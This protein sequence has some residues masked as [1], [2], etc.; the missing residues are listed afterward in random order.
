VRGPCCPLGGPHAPDHCGVRGG[1]CI[2]KG[3]F[4]SPSQAAQTPSMCCTTGPCAGLKYLVCVV[5]CMRPLP[6]VFSILDRK[7]GGSTHRGGIACAQKWARRFTPHQL[8]PLPDVCQTNGLGGCSLRH[9]TYMADGVWWARGERKG[10]HARWSG[11]CRCVNN[12]RRLP[13]G[14]SAGGW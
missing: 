14:A 5:C 11:C 7:E 2:D 10:A 8:D 3:G 12:G 1:M 9:V 6:D 13:R 4:A